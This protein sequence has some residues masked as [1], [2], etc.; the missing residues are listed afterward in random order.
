MRKCSYWL[1]KSE[2]SGYSF[3]DLINEDN[4]T[5]E[6][7]GVRNYAAR[8]YLRDQVRIGD[9]VF[10]YHSNITT[11]AIVGTAGVVREGYPDF[12]AWDP[13]SEH[14]DSKSTPENPIWFMVDIKADGFLPNEVTLTQI[15]STA[16]LWNTSLLKRAR[17]SV[18][19]V[20]LDE[21]TIILELSKCG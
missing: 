17:L 7:D 21:W 12:T 1:F 2:P 4:H 14:P 9:K 8:N 15:K 18:H 5:A 10:F 19:P 13:T 20:T 11:P 6:W 3:Q 16:E